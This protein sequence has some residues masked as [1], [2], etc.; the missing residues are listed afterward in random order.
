MS[1]CGI[2]GSSTMEH[3]RTSPCP[4]IKQYSKAEQDQALQ[5][6]TYIPDDWEVSRMLDDYR[7]LRDQIRDCR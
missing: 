3:G 1:G 5:E 6:L 7:L 4:P 2:I